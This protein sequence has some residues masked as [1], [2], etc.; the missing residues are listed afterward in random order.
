V[1]RDVEAYLDA[2]A[3]RIAITFFE[4]AVEEQVRQAERFGEE[5]I[6]QFG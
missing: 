1:V 5:V 3:T 2:G 6:A 4:D